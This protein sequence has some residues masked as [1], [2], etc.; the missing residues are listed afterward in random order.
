MAIK[1]IRPR[2]IRGAVYIYTRDH[3]TWSPAAYVKASNTKEAAEF[4]ISVALNSDGKILAVG[5]VKED[6]G[7]ERR[8]PERCGCD[9]ESVRCSYVYY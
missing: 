6:G 5:A 8:E 2:K 4:G 1:Q 7:R 9:G 3:N